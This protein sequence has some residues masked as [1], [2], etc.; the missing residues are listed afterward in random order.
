MV[1]PAVSSPLLI[2]DALCV[3]G[4]MVLLVSSNEVEDVVVAREVIVSSLLDM[5]DL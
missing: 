4:M 1:M 2:M 3:E 5:V